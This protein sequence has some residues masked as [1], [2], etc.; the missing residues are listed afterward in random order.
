MSKDNLKNK[1]PY[2]IIQT[3]NAGRTLVATRDIKAQELIL[4]DEAPIV[5]PILYSGQVNFKISFFCIVCFKLC[6]GSLKCPRCK[7]PICDKN[8]AKLKTHIEDCP[9]LRDV[10]DDEDD[11]KGIESVEIVHHVTVLSL[12]IQTEKFSNDFKIHLL[13]KWISFDKILP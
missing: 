2:K 3:P 4:T 6:R 12:L 7:L 11:P 8:C 5:A 9:V 10:F 1:K 13:S